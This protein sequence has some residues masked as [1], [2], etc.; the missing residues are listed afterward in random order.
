MNDHCPGSHC[1]RWDACHAMAIDDDGK[2]MVVE[3]THLF[4]IP[5][6]TN[7]KALCWWIVNKH[8]DIELG[9]IEWTGK[10]HWRR[11]AFFPRPDT[12]YEEV[13]LRDIAA[14]CEAKTRDHKQRKG[15]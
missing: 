1:R 8:D 10:E 4:F 2:C 12:M 13:C 6:P 3:T 11:Y 15:G 5:G 9:S 14:F 7:Q